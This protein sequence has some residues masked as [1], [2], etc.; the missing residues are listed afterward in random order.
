MHELLWLPSPRPLKSWSQLHHWQTLCLNTLHRKLA[1]GPVFC[2]AAQGGSR[3][4]LHSSHT[5]KSGRIHFRG[6][7]ESPTLCWIPV[8]LVP[9]QLKQPTEDWMFPTKQFCPE[10]VQPFC[11]L[12]KERT[13]WFYYCIFCTH[14]KERVRSIPGHSIRGLEDVSLIA[15]WLL[16]FKQLWI[17]CVCG[18]MLGTC[19]RD[20]SL[21][22][23]VSTSALLWV[24]VPT[25]T[26]MTVTSGELG[27]KWPLARRQRKLPPESSSSSVLQTIYVTVNTKGTRPWALP[28]VGM[29]VTFFT[30]HPTVLT[31]K[32]FR[33]LALSLF[34]SQ[35]LA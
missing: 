22:F 30:P 20:L 28:G 33:G 13:L 1:W 6:P 14:W 15:L 31:G 29:G 19:H 18:Y 24:K 23:C 27:W 7:L 35:A 2:L 10:P 4:Y 21:P 34:S 3:G 16:V 17:V 11:V 12:V 8:S 5:L 26:Y 25:A 32:H 9:A